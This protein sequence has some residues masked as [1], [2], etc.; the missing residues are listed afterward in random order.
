MAHTSRLSD[1]CGDV[2]LR[3]STCVRDG[4]YVHLLIWLDL[5]MICVHNWDL[6]VS[7]FF[8]VHIILSNV[9]TKCVCMGALLCRNIIDNTANTAF[10][11]CC[12]CNRLYIM[13]CAGLLACVHVCMSL[14]ADINE[15]ASSGMN[16]CDD[17]NALCTNTRGSYMCSCK[18][19]F[20]GTG[21]TAE[22]GCFGTVL[23]WCF[24]SF[25][26]EDHSLFCLRCHDDRTFV[27]SVVFY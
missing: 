23:D 11:L 22:N 8:Y 21:R 10:R 14:I 3:V 26:N 27:P 24:P 2:C 25:N 4:M 9:L 13:F 1:M 6:F 19:G 7:V 15:C 18:R 12:V 5:G 17:P 20:N 16:D